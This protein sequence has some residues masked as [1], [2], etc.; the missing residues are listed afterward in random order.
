ML[1]RRFFRASIS[2]DVLTRKHRDETKLLF[3]SLKHS[4]RIVPRKHC[5]DTP[6]C[7]HPDETQP[8][9]SLLTNFVHTVPC[10]TFHAFSCAQASL[11]SNVVISFIHSVNRKLEKSTVDRNFRFLDYCCRPLHA[12][13]RCRIPSCSILFH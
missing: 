3:S 11:W 12:I 1:T 8:L 2:M 10:K 5:L 13:A 6:T 4:A 9:F 7:K